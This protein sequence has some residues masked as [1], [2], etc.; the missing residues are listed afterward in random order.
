MLNYLSRYL[1][2]LIG[3]EFMLTIFIIFENTGILMIPKQKG[4]QAKK[5]FTNIYF[6]LR[7]LAFGLI[8]VISF[9]YLSSYKKNKAQSVNETPIIIEK[10]SN[11]E[12]NANKNLSKT[13]LYLGQTKGSAR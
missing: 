13:R 8:V 4:E 5:D 7:T 2:V 9:L 11:K 6:Y 3:L 1:N 12:S 10:Q